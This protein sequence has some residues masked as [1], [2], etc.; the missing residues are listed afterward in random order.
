MFYRGNFNAAYVLDIKKESTMDADLHRID[1]NLNKTEVSISSKMYRMGRMNS[2]NE[3]SFLD[4]ETNLTILSHL[5]SS[6]HSPCSNMFECIGNKRW[7]APSRKGNQ[8]SNRP[9]QLY[10]SFYNNSL[11]KEANGQSLI[12]MTLDLS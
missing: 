5:N 2:K 12:D 4:S 6:N 9:M 7:K 8:A 11:Q 1:S 3:E 10:G